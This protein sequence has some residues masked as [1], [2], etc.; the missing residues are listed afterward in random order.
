MREVRVSQIVHQAQP[1]IRALGMI[2]WIVFAVFALFPT[3]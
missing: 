3:A 1:A 2:G